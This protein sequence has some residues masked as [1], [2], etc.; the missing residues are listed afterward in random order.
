MKQFIQTFKE[1]EKN[2]HDA[3]LI[4]F[5]SGLG[6]LLCLLS[7][8]IFRQKHLRDIHTINLQT[9]QQLRVI[10]Q[11]EKACGG[12]EVKYINYWEDGQGKWHYQQMC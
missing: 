7:L 10:K 5:I 8:F 6:M 11:A 12:K 1:I 2:Y 9:E 3:I 4:G